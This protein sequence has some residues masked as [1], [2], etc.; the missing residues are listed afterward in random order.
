ME[1]E[2]ERFGETELRDETWD[3]MTWIYLLGEGIFT[4]IARDFAPLADPLLLQDETS[5]RAVS[6]QLP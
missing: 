1:L 4:L 6:N 5:S 2:A 3:A